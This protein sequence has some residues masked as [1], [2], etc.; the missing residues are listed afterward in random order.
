MG[1]SMMKMLKHTSSG[2]FN[3]DR[4]KTRNRYNQTNLIAR[5]RKPNSFFTYYKKVADLASKNWMMAEKSIG[6]KRG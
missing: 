1:L 3:E 6:K 2:N 5:E 4:G